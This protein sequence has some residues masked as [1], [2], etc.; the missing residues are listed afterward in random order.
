MKKSNE[1]NTTT[2]RSVYNKLYKRR[3][4]SCDYCK[5]HGPHSENDQWDS[6][7]VSKTVKGRETKRYPNWKLVSKNS[8]QWMEKPL[9]YKEYTK[10]PHFWEYYYDIIW[11]IKIKR[12]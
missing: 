11:P 2:N 6:Y 9:K 4:A 7:S 3:H 1:Y 12:R 8:K 10:R 5:W